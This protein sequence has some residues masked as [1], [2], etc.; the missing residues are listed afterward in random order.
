[1]Y[2]FVS[3]FIKLTRL[4]FPCWVVCFMMNLLFLLFFLFF[5]KCIPLRGSYFPAGGKE[6]SCRFAPVVVLSHTLWEEATVPARGDPYIGWG[7]LWV[8]KRHI[9]SLFWLTWCCE[10]QGNPF[11]AVRNSLQ[12]RDS[13]TQVKLRRHSI[14]RTVGSVIIPLPSISSCKKDWKKNAPHLAPMACAHGGGRIHE[15]LQLHQEPKGGTKP[16]FLDKILSHKALTLLH[17]WWEFCWAISLRTHKLY[18]K[19][20]QKCT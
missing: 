7:G 3:N 17:T 13:V 16:M 4:N 12:L 9:L 8:S 5:G 19:Q 15:C 10:E 2:S 18:G 1:M 14:P 20:A 6:R 11:C